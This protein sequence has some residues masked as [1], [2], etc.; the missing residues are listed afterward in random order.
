M[1]YW[2]LLLI[3]VFALAA[4]FGLYYALRDEMG[5]KKDR[6]DRIIKGQNREE[7]MTEAKELLAS[8]QPQQQVLTLRKKIKPVSCTDEECVKT[9][10]YHLIPQ[11]EKALSILT[12]IMPLMLISC[13]VIVIPVLLFTAPLGFVILFACV[14]AIFI[15]EFWWVFTRIFVTFLQEELAYLKRI[16]E[17][18]TPML[19]VSE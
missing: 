17:H 9:I 7:C 1:Y 3:A 2:L 10:R 5:R 16:D 6:Y 18:L 19:E 4:P 11:K 12:R 14:I 8:I 13:P 15:V